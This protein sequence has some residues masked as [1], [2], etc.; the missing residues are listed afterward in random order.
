[1]LSQLQYICLDMHKIEMNHTVT[2]IYM[3]LLLYTDPTHTHTHT[4]LGML[5]DC[6]YF[7]INER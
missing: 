3:F 6:R 5:I 1:M 7:R 2:Y 4:H